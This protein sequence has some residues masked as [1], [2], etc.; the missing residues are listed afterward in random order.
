[1]RSLGM[2]TVLPAF[3]GHVP[4]GVLRY[5]GLRSQTPKVLELPAQ[6][7]LAPG[8]T[9]GQ[10]RAPLGAPAQRAQCVLPSCF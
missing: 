8:P 10:H 1:M 2:I 7:V 9:F 5:V 3:A 6:R 4:Q